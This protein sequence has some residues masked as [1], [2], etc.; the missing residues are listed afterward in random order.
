[1]FNCYGS[2]PPR[3]PSIPLTSWCSR[4]CVVLTPTESGPTHMINR[5]WLKLHDVCHFS[6]WL[7]SQRILPLGFLEH[8]FWTQPLTVI[9]GS[10]A[11]SRSGPLGEK[12]TCQ[13][14]ST[15]QT[16]GW[17]ALKVDSPSPVQKSHEKPYQSC[18]NEPVPNSLHTKIVRDNMSLCGLK[19]LVLG[20][21]VKLQ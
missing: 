21:F 8:S 7:C 5:I 20:W 17:Y 9:W 19:P 14:Q 13:H 15:C 11:V 3:W 18:L 10:Q 4:V 2:Q 6:E 16:G 1:M 12:Q